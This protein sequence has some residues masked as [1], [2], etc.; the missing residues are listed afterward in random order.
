MPGDVVADIEL[1]V[2]PNGVRPQPMRE[3]ECT[4]KNTEDSR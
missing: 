1:A 4:V 2:D 3:Q